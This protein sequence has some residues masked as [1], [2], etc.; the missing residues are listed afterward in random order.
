MCQY[1]DTSVRDDDCDAVLD[2]GGVLCMTCI[3]A[4]EYII[5]V[6]RHTFCAYI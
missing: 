2:V 5:S 4:A 3:C 6:D 1:C